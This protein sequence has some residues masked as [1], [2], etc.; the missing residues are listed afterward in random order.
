MED[1]LL[2]DA[3]KPYFCNYLEQGNL[4]IGVCC[5]IEDACVYD[6]GLN[7]QW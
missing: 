4:H 7:Q 1:A 2:M 6:F 5:D 3:T